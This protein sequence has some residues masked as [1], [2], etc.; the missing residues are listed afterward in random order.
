MI[1]DMITK[2]VYDGK[3]F[4]K[5]QKKKQGPSLYEKVRRGGHAGD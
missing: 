5:P 1:E 4:V 2:H 3:P